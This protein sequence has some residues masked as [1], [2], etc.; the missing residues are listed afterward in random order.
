MDDDIYEAK[1]AYIN[2]H[3]L[4]LFRVIRRVIITSVKTT[5]MSEDLLIARE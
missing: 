4:Q 3:Y 1:R 5:F 2:K